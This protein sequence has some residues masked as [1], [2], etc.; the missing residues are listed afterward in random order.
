MRLDRF[1]SNA[2]VGTRSE[3]KKLIRSGS[4]TVNGIVV[5]DEAYH[6]CDKDLVQ[7]SGT[8][9][10]PHRKVYLVF[11][12]PAGYVSDRTEDEAS[13][14]D[15]IDHPYSDELQVAGR[16]DKDVEGLLILSNDGSFIHRII[17]PKWHVEKEYLVHF[18][19]ELTSQ[20]IQAVSEGL[21][22]GV[23]R[24][25]PAKIRLL[26]PGLLSLTIR[27][28]KYHQ[29]K[30]MMKA[31]DLRY[32]KIQRIRIGNIT[33]GNLR[34]GEFRELSEQEIKLLFLNP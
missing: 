34:F 8:V 2:K 21:E 13:I 31:L 26:T 28:G 5:K 33:L 7:L 6:I 11:N 17:S 1:L 12:K 25:K 15:L 18:E 10:K 24:F 9:V 14:Y 32:T 23:E 19:G 4:V 16:L 30:K 29:V 22:V 3:V 20:K 27:E